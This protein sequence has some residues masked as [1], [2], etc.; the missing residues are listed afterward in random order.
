M[1]DRLT[2]DPEAFV[3]FLDDNYKCNRPIPGISRYELK[4]R[5]PSKNLFGV[6]RM[7]VV[8]NNGFSP[9]QG[10][11]LIEMSDVDKDY[12]GLNNVTRV[13][14]LWHSGGTRHYVRPGRI[15]GESEER[16]RI[17]I[18]ENV[19]R[20]DGGEIA[21]QKFILHYGSDGNEDEAEIEQLSGP[22]QLDYEN[23]VWRFAD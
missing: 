1:R 5:S 12:W 23:G 17:H 4:N 20:A 16:L 15:I 21:P 22:R 18:L 7:K 6:K 2:L 10:G 14:N 13:A 9:V 8:W 3:K 19:P 11:S